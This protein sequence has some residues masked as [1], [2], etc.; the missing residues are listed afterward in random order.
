MIIKE[1][2][3][4]IVE[5][6]SPIVAIKMDKEKLPATVEDLKQFIFITRKRIEAHRVLI[7]GVKG[8]NVS[9]IVYGRKLKEAQYMS[10]LVLFAEAK[11]GNILK[12]IEKS[13][14]RKLEEDKDKETELQKTGYKQTHRHRAYMLDRN[15]GVIQ[16]II[17]E[18]IKKENLPTR[19]KVFRRIREKKAESTRSKMRK[20]AKGYRSEGKKPKVICAD[21]YRYCMKN[22]KPNSIDHIVTDPPY[23]VE[24]LPLWDQLSEVAERVLKPGGFC[25]AYCGTYYLSEVLDRMRNHLVYYWQIV[26]ELSGAS[27]RVHPRNIY[28][29]YRSVLV[30]SKKPM[31]KQQSMTLDFIKKCER[32]K[33]FHEWQQAQS[34]FEE[35]LDKFTTPGQMILE[36]FGGAGTVPLACLEKDRKCLCIEINEEDVKIIKGRLNIAYNKLD[37]TK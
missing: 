28:Q 23:P 10:G 26:I 22:V 17:D 4:T 7:E 5:K 31:K 29:G 25:I 35:L 33:D 24:F 3:L 20:Q 30:F 21:F 19:E 8:L 34:G 13:R 15:R 27:A 12:G 9:K 14:G 16:E 1:K 11:I 2:S 6:E 37:K 18:E 36:P 32:E